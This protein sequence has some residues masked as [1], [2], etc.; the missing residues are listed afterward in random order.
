MAYFDSC[1]LFVLSLRLNLKKLDIKECLK[2]FITCL[3][4]LVFKFGQFLD[5]KLI[6]L[7]NY[8]RFCDFDP[9]KWHLLTFTCA[10]FLTLRLNIKKIIIKECLNSNMKCLYQFVLRFG[11]I[12]GFKLTYLLN[13]WRFC[14]FDPPKGHFLAFFGKI[15]AQSVK[16]KKTR[17]SGHLKNVTFLIY[18]FERNI[19]GPNSAS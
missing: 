12:L 13:Y 6:Y 8:C 16:Y 18:F 15:S 5:F 11:Q 19:L 9:S 2:C 3:Y 7:L 4:Q 1:T 14:D 17:N 10:I